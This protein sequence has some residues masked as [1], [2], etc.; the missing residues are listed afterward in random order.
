M[1]QLGSIRSRV[2]PKQRGQFISELKVVF[3]EQE[4]RY[5]RVVIENLGKCPP[6]HEAAGADAW[7]FADE[8]VAR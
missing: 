8:I 1:Q 4:V 5:L 7:I 6:W 3:E 2:D